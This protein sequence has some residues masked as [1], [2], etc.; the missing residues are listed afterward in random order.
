MH[1]TVK[2]YLSI[3][4]NYITYHLQKWVDKSV[5]ILKNEVEKLEKEGW[6]I[7]RENGLLRLEN[8]KGEKFYLRTKSSDLDVFN[9]IIVNKSYSMLVDYA[10]KKELSIETIVDC[11]ANIGLFSVFIKKHFPNSKIVAIEP[12]TPNLAIAKK[13]FDANKLFIKTIEG[14]VWSQKTKLAVSRDFRDGREWAITMAEKENAEIESFTLIEIMRMANIKNIDIL[15][16]DIEGAESQLFDKE[17]S[18]VSFL[19]CT[20]MIA[21]EIHDEFH[22][23]EKIELLLNEFGFELN[24]DGE[25]TIGIKSLKNGKKN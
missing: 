8:K 15:K 4:L 7:R 3:S 16:I 12:F 14:A 13:N 2:E 18:D 6:K 19:E 20:N 25:L 1:F 10:L 11:G 9:Q 23:R 17:L 5:I 21:I 24:N 22:C